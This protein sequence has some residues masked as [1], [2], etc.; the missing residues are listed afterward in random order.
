M[1]GRRSSLGFMGRFGRS[2]DLR[3]LDQALRA[4][5]LHPALVPEGVKLAIVNLM[6]D[7]IGNEA[8]PET[9]PPVGDLFACCVLGEQDFIQDNGDERFAAVDV[10]IQRAV[11]AG[12]G[13][14]ADLLLLALHSQLID[15]DLVGTLW[16]G[17]G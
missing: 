5:G 13:L 15:R 11:E 17:G 16:A 10:R 9:Y 8:G 1:A 2:A 7:H 4:G 3:Q 14:D 12:E 6:G